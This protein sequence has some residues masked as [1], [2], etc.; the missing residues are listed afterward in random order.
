MKQIFALTMTLAITM[1]SIAQA[2]ELGL[3]LPAGWPDLGP[4]DPSFPVTTMPSSFDWTE[5]F[6][7]LPVRDQGPCGSCWA[8]ATVGALEYQ[9]LINEREAVD[10]SEQWLLGCASA[11]GL[12]CGGGWAAH[13]YFLDSTSESDPCGGKGA[14]LESQ[15][16]Y[17]AIDTTCGCPYTHSYLID[18]WSYIGLIPGVLATDDQIKN[19][20]YQHG[21]L[22][23][24][25][26]AG[27]PGFDSS[28]D[29]GVI[30]PCVG[31]LPNHA[32]LIVGWDDGL[33]AWKIRNSWGADWGESG[34]GWIAYGCSNIGFAASYVVYPEGKG[35]WL[36]WS[37]SGLVER[38]W[39]NEPYNSLP[40]ALGALDDGGTLSI[41]TGSNSVV[42]LLTKEMTIQP[43]GGPVVLGMAE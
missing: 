38:G 13:N 16:P 18:H 25:V 5:L 39:F 29:S 15:L 1:T 35:V 43:F 32:V 36:D 20:V 40:E 9:I 31:A 10:L 21:P 8:F 23:V 7:Q 37:F 30:S 17:A 6:P 33:G 14:V 3:E 12:D 28:Y 24:T 27:Y 42:G 4:W 19:A 22:F 26:R 11:D 34:Y 41:K 2:Q